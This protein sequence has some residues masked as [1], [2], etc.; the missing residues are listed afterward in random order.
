[1]LETFTS[2]IG[3][4]EEKSMIFKDMKFRKDPLFDLMIGQMTCHNKGH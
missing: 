3:Q 2:N 1:M 4:V